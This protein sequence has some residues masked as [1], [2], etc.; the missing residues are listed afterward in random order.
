MDKNRVLIIAEFEAHKGE[1]VI[2]NDRLARLI[3]VVDDKEDYYWLFFDGRKL[4]MTSCLVSFIPLK[5][6]IDDKDY[7][8]LI[9]LAKLNHI[10]LLENVVKGFDQEKFKVDLIG[11]LDDNDEL[12]TEVCWTL[13]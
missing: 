10:D 1:I 11:D 13:N 2:Q 9:R 4:S 12:I 8:E 6:K 7:S 5:G 3:G